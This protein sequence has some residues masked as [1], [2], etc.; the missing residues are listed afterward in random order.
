MWWFRVTG[1]RA[2]IEL[3]FMVFSCGLVTANPGTL[4]L[5]PTPC[6]WFPNP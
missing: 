3:R 1:F 5:N 4:T 6:Q 2:L